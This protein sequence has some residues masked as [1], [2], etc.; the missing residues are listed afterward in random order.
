MAE[1]PDNNC[2]SYG[3]ATPSEQRTRKRHCFIGLIVSSLPATPS[4]SEFAQDV[5]DNWVQNPF[6]HD[7]ASEIAFAFALVW[8]HHS[9]LF[10]YVC[11]LVFCI[12]D[13]IIT[14]RV[15]GTVMFSDCLY[16]CLCVCSGCNF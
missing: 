12:S 10:G 13:N 2:D 14:A 4:E 1:L 8:L 7:F 15:C 11:L 9:A 5:A 3:Q 6:C 16:V